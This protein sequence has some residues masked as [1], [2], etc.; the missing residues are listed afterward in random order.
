MPARAAS[1]PRLSAAERRE[2]LLDVTKAIVD[3]RG[4]H[5]VSIEAVARDAGITRPVVYGHFQ[6]LPGL[7]EA[8]V[9]REGARALAQL[10]AV[11]PSD[12]RAGDARDLLDSALAGYLSAVQ[13]DP[14]TW[15]L[16]LMPPEGAPAV[17]REHIERGRAA[18]LTQLASAAGPGLVPGRES[19]DPELTARMLSAFADEAARLLLTDPER[20]PVPR[21]MAHTEWLL[22]QLTS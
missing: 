19:P 6:D 22:D 16:V 18:V 17:L 14:A 4:F 13:A 3:E 12:L 9:E 7:L 8:L 20:W 5:A 1:P 21:L 2:Q 10:A 11:L 15:R